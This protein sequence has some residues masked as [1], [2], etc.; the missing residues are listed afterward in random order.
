MKDLITILDK[1]ATALAQYS[2]SKKLYGNLALLLKEAS[3]EMQS[4]QDRI[5]T[6]E[7]EKSELQ[8]AL[9]LNKLGISPD[10]GQ[11]PL[12]FLSSDPDI[13][14]PG[15]ATDVYASPMDRFT[16]LLMKEGGYYE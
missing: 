2:T 5:D 9:A 12:D 7:T 1:T 3:M 8:A 16:A 15:E 10:E 4:L 13:L 11:S 14:S 6:L